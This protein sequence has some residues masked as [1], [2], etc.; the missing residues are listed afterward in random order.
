[1]ATN[2]EWYGDL[3]R[4]AIEG[5]TQTLSDVVERELSPVQMLNIAKAAWLLVKTL[6]ACQAK[7]SS[8]ARDYDRTQR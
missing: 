7:I 2:D 1:M 6:N 3:L 8:K 5:D 4:L